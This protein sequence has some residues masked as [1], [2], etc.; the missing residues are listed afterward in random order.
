MQKG[1]SMTEQNNQLIIDGK[2]VDAKVIQVNGKAGLHGE[3]VFTVIFEDRTTQQLTAAE[4]RRHEEAN[5][6][7]D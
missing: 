5:I 4:R 3:A 6:E 1:L 2:F 7:E